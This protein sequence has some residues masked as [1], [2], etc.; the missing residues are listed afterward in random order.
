MAGDFKD[1]GK[2]DFTHFFQAVVKEEL[3]YILE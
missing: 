2:S 1:L 3:V